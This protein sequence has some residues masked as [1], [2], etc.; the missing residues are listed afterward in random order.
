MTMIVDRPP[1]LEI[2]GS[3]VSSLQ[4]ISSA[5]YSPFSSLQSKIFSLTNL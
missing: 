2:G 4:Q 3:T 5:F 1:N